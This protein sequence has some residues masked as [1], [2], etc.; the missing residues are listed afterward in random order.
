MKNRRAFT[1]IELLVVIAIF[2]ILMAI[3]IPLIQ[4][5][6]EASRRAYDPQY[7]QRQKEAAYVEET[8]TIEIAE[9]TSDVFI[10]KEGRREV[11][12][13]NWCTYLKDFI[14]NKNRKVINLNIDCWQG[15]AGDIETVV[16]VFGAEQ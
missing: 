6:R 13:S 15:H 7:E 4:V 14:K 2:A 5:A 11:D 1:L 9:I 12:Y 16:I 8:A 3:L 10:L